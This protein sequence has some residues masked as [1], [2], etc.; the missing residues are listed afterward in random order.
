MSSGLADSDAPEASKDSNSGTFSLAGTQLTFAEE[1]M[2]MPVWQ[3]LD[4]LFKSPVL[5]ASIALCGE[6][7]EKNS[8]A[9]KP[10]L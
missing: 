2:F 4:I 3:C 8:C 7:G 10:R 6:R 1:I 5:L 9:S